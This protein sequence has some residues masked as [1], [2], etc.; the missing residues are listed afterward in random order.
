[1]ITDIFQPSLSNRKAT[2]TSD[3]SS[4]PLLSADG[5]PLALS[6]AAGAREARFSRARIPELNRSPRFGTISETVYNQNGV[7]NG[8]FD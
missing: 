2:N 3:P 8:L 1:M 4:A 6:A 7:N 5:A